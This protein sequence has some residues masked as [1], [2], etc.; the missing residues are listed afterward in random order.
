MARCSSAIA[1]DAAINAGLVVIGLLATLARGCR[2]MSTCEIS[3]GQFL[4]FATGAHSAHAVQ[5]MESEEKIG[6]L[7]RNEDFPFRLRKILAT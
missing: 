4:A 6:I 3:D 1:C 2:N 5:A 7:A